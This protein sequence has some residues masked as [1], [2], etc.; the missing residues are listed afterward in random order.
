MM[1]LECA[2]RKDH[3]A[4][5]K[6]ADQ[7]QPQW[8]AQP[9][10]LDSFDQSANRERQPGQQEQRHGDEVEKP[11]LR[12]SKFPRRPA[13]NFAAPNAKNIWIHTPCCQRPT[14]QAYQKNQ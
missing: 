5:H 3:Q 1:M 13:E 4:W 8:P 9:L 6:P 7:E 12:R 2:E 14:A 11:W 10:T